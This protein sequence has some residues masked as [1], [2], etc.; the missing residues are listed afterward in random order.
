MRFPRSLQ[1]YM[2][3]WGSATLESREVQRTSRTLQRVFVVS[4]WL[5][6]L[7]EGGRSGKMSWFDWSYLVVFRRVRLISVVLL[8]RDGLFIHG[9]PGGVESWNLNQ[10]RLF[11]HP[12]MQTS[13]LKWKRKIIAK[14]L[15]LRFNVHVQGFKQAGVLYGSGSFLAALSFDSNNPSLKSVRLKR[16]VS[17]FYLCRC[18]CFFT[19]MHVLLVGILRYHILPDQMLWT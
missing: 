9:H 12:K 7:F 14:L 1:R 19:W 18:P 16:K 13:N 3:L 15:I 8:Y 2:A 4:K 6:L 17:I 11:E 10:L 5:G